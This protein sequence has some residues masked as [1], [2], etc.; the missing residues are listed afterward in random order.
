MPI[1]KTR[2][3]HPAPAQRR[4]ALPKRIDLGGPVE[5]RPAG[6]GLPAQLAARFRRPNG[7]QGDPKP[8]SFWQSDRAAV[9]ATAVVFSPIRGRFSATYRRGHPSARLPARFSPAALAVVENG[10]GGGTLRG[11]LAAATQARSSALKRTRAHWGKTLVGSPTSPTASP[12]SKNVG[13]AKKLAP[14]SLSPSA[15]LSGTQRGHGPSARLPAGI[16][17]TALTVVE[18]AGGGTCGDFEGL[19]GD[20]LPPSVATAFSLRFRGGIFGDLQGGLSGTCP[21]SLGFVLCSDCGGAFGL[22]YVTAE[23]QAQTRWDRCLGRV[24]SRFKFGLED[25][26]SGTRTVFYVRTGHKDWRVMSG[27]KFGFSSART[28]VRRRAH[29]EADETESPE[30]SGQSRSHGAAVSHLV[31]SSSVPIVLWQFFGGNQAATQRT[32]R[33]SRSTDLLATKPPNEEPD[34]KRLEI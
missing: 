34:T 19:S 7:T 1:S 33:Q 25:T 29:L 20:F 11:L 8:P 17:P 24:Q 12:L 6:Y 15:R 21:L 32:H 22:C 18:N 28:A 30:V 3:N 5:P 23:A 16:S 9:A 2:P 14:R 27:P 26:S 10:G 31:R 4:A 13:T